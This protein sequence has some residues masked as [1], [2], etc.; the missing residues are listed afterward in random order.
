MPP[1][2][3]GSPE[4]MRATCSPLG[5]PARRRP[6]RPP[7]TSPPSRRSRRLAGACSST[8]AC[9]RLAAQTTTSASAMAA[10]R[11]ERQQ[12]GGARSGADEGHATGHNFPPRVRARPGSAPSTGTAAA[13]STRVERSHLLVRQPEVAADARHPRSARRLDAR[14]P[15]GA[16]RPCRPPPWRP[17]ASASLQRRQVAA[18]SGSSDER[19]AAFDERSPGCRRQRLHRGDPRDGLDHLDGRAALAH[20]LRRGSRRWSTRWGR[21]SWRTRRC[22]RSPAATRHPAAGRVPVV[23]PPPGVRP[24]VEREHQPLDPVVPRRARA[25]SPRPARLGRVEHGHEHP[26]R[27]RAAPAPPLTSP[28][29]GSPGPPRRR[30]GRMRPPVQPAA[31]PIRRAGCAG[32]VQVQVGGVHV[33]RARSPRPGRRRASAT[34]AS[35]PA[36]GVTAVRWN[37]CAGQPGVPAGASRARRRPTASR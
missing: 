33:A 14:S 35:A 13:P 36:P 7:A 15:P 16:G 5:A 31:R 4:W 9:T 25:R 12:V 27:R 1:H 30:S 24:V 10:R 6:R 18:V 37:S 19:L 32:P 22:R 11:P 26:A 34:P 3:A 29:P 17:G 8:S 28:A 20:G 21:R 23:L 2:S